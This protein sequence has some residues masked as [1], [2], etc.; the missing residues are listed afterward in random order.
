MTVARFH[1]IYDVYANSGLYYLPHL[2][3]Q[4]ISCYR[5]RSFIASAFLWF[6]FLVDFVDMISQ[7]IPHFAA[8]CD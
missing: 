7:L 5:R 1:T 3:M 6:T 8:Y 2:N 4:D